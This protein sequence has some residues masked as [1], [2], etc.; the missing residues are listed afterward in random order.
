V[1]VLVVALVALAS[2]VT[3]LG[4]HFAY[5]DVQ[6]VLR[7]ERVHSLAEPWRFFT[8]TY[9]PPGKFQ[10]GA[11][12][13][14]PL[15]SFAVAVQWVLAGGH[16]MVFHATNILLAVLIS[17]SFLW[18]AW[19]LLP[20]PGA[21]VAAG[22]FAAHPVHVEAVANIVGQGEL[23]VNLFMLL[24][25][26]AF[27]SG[28]RRALDR[29][30]E[31]RDRLAVYG[32]YALA[33]L[34][35][36]NG[37]ILPGLLLAAELTVVPDPRPLRERLTALRSF[38]TILVGVGV[39]YLA[40]RTT[41]TGTLAGDYPH[42]LIGTASYPERL[43]TMLRVALEWPRLL[44]WPAHLQADYSPRDFDRAL[45]FGALQFAGLAMLLASAWLTIWTWR[46]RPV[47]A[48]GMLWLAVAI[49]PVSNLVLKAGIVLAERTLF[50]ASAGAMLAVGAAGAVIAELGPRPRVV[51]AAAG[52][53]LA[54]LGG[55]RSALRQPVWKDNAT[56]FAQTVRDAPY[57]YRAH[58][59]Y[60]L[61][62][63]E[64]GQ[65]E[66]AFTE[67]ATAIGLYP[68]DPTMYSDAGDLYRTDGQ[69]ERSIQLYQS[70]LDLTPDMKYT[71]SRLASCYMRLGAYDAARRELRRLVADGY[72][73]FGE[74]LRAVD[75]AAAA[76]GNFR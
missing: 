18:L 71:R 42:I 30:L 22:L 33:C 8:Q 40:L 68:A 31:P 9:W 11:T 4:N 50:L 53:T 63:F 52:A 56:L 45:S 39:L 73:E 29:G 25:V 36:D 70:A 24:A 3:G 59:T 14:R 72:P 57:N 74:L 17:V 37:I 43:Y 10:G 47:V 6:A 2:S 64:H 38:W 15:T 5:D 54:V 32:C 55:V 1:L 23:W 62:L 12:L 41:V 35:K 67:I 49:F 20:P 66:A 48:F 21:L 58:W 44:L 69:C 65:R 34:S 13:Y 27:L 19:Q 76:S 60:S 26:V 16:P 75:S 61:F 7:N 51:V 46:R 28:R